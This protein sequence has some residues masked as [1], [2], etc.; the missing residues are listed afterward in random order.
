[1]QLKNRSITHYVQFHQNLKLITLNDHNKL[2]LLDPWGIFFGNVLS[3][4][5][6]FILLNFLIMLVKLSMLAH[7]KWVSRHVAVKLCCVGTTINLTQYNRYQLPYLQGHFIQ[8]YVFKNHKL[9]TWRRNNTSVFYLITFSPSTTKH[10]Y[11][12]YMYVLNEWMVTQL[13][14]KVELYATLIKFN[15]KNIK[16]RGQKWDQ[17]AP[18]CTYRL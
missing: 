2:P 18:R 1:M 9:T 8:L 3:V 16:D 6:T 15:T 14:I 4:L 17:G 10:N 11:A 12:M 13:L 7:L 5:D